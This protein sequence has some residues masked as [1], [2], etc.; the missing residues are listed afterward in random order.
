MNDQYSDRRGELPITPDNTHIV[1]ASVFF[2]FVTGLLYYLVVMQK[3]KMSHA[4]KFELVVGF[5]L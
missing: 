1:N 4:A 3:K 2:V 5:E